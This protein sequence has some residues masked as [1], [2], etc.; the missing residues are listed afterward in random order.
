MWLKHS[1]ITRDKLMNNEWKK[2]S[3]FPTKKEEISLY[4]MVGIGGKKKENDC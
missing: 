4:G 3:F 2:E 1:P